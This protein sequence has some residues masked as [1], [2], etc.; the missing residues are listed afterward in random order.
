MHWFWVYYACNCVCWV[1]LCVFIKILSS[2]L[3][4]M[5]IVDKHCSDICCAEFLVPQTDRKSKQVKEH[6]TQISQCYREFEGGN[7]CWDTVYIYLCICRQNSRQPGIL[8]WFAAEGENDL[9]NVQ[10]GT[11]CRRRVVGQRVVSDISVVHSCW[12]TCSLCSE[13]NNT[14]LLLCLL[15]AVLETSILL[16]TPNVPGPTTC[17][18]VLGEDR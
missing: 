14:N 4:T 8:A 16:H 11:C 6:R 1:Y 13:S 3:N 7:F 9:H 12:S 2:S 15:I 10:Y 5:L 17:R 18:S